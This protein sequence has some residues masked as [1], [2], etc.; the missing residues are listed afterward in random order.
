[1]NKS[2]VS[3]IELFALPLLILPA[4]LAKDDLFFDSDFKL[5]TEFGFA[6]LIPF[7]QIPLFC[8][9][10]SRRRDLAG[11]RIGPIAGSIA[12]GIMV[13]F[14]CGLM[15]SLPAYVKA[16]SLI[17]ANPWMQAISPQPRMTA[18]FLIPIKYAIAGIGFSLLFHI[19]LR[20]LQGRSRDSETIVPTKRRRTGDVKAIIGFAF[21]A[22]L[23]LY[24][25]ILR[26]F[27]GIYV[28]ITNG[29][30]STMNTV[31]V[32]VEGR[33][34]TF[35][36]LRTGEQRTFLVRPQGVSTVAVSYEIDG[37]MN[38][39]DLHGYLVTADDRGTIKVN[40]KNSIVY[41]KPNLYKA[42]LKYY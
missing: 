36:D 25:F 6:L 41:V 5:R 8:F 23:L 22:S 11:L 33:D 16:A 24:V 7:L 27:A 35:G 28:T 42:E 15:I 18:F 30:T 31:Q 29:E 39:E 20:A 32:H 40:F 17:E 1:M 38:R 19:L 10:I 34:Y 14:S 13:G 2:R 9:L 3:L 21:A 4:L 12:I 37:K 26:P